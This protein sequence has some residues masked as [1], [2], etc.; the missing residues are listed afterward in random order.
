M[1]E[2]IED[3]SLV[4]PRSILTTYILNGIVDFPMLIA[5]LFSIT[6]VNAALESPTQYP[7]MQIFLTATNSPGGAT[8]MASIPTIMEICATTSSLAAAS[9]QFWSFSRDHGVPGWRHF[10]KV[11]S[12]NLSDLTLDGFSC[13]KARRLARPKLTQGPL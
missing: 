10:S 6:D 13:H 9:R 3:A 5:V 7:F 12:S 11:N 8:A 1:S 2:K 4:V